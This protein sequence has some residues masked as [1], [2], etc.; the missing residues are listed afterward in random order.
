MSTSVLKALPGKLDIKRHS[1]STLYVSSGA[2]RLNFG[3]SLMY[4][5]TLC[6]QEMKALAR[7]RICTGSHEPSLL[8]NAISTKILHA[9]PNVNGPNKKN[10]C[11]SGNESEDF[12]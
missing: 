8:V 1:L 11:V 7:L 4:L 3:L 6:I 10:L 12:W 5:H 9:G 2:R